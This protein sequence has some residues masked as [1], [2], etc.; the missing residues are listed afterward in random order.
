MDRT[1][2]RWLGIGVP[3]FLVSV[4]L[5]A[6]LVAGGEDADPTPPSDAP[7]SAATSTPAP[8][9][10]ETIGE[11]GGAS[12]SDDDLPGPQTSPTLDSS[13]SPTSTPTPL[14]AVDPSTFPFQRPTPPSGVVEIR[15]QT[16]NL[17]N[18]RKVGYRDAILPVYHPSFTDAEDAGLR[19]WELVLGVEIDGEAK[20]YPI[21]PLSQ[22]EM[23]N[24][25][26]GG[27]PLLVTW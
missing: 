21:G 13:P 23:V 11:S 3:L 22:R 5:V 1:W 24:D 15:G 16:F 25:R 9:D 8:T 19:N 12:A 20:A 4:V 6:V 7:V 18:L 10:G 27:V 2:F 17:S 14:P 26:L